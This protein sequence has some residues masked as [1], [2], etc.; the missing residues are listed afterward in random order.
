M[1]RRTLWICI[2]CS[3]WLSIRWLTIKS[4]TI[5]C[6][7]I[8]FVWPEYFGLWV[9]VHMYITMNVIDISTIWIAINSS[10][11]N[12]QSV[13]SYSEPRPGP[14]YSQVLGWCWCGA[15]MLWIYSAGCPLGGNEWISSGLCGWSR[16]SLYHGGTTWEKTIF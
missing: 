8:F 3:F 1:Y 13:F 9:R 12:G 5:E 2:Y 10:P 14:E 4:P 16:N 7:F 6:F 11:K 15:G